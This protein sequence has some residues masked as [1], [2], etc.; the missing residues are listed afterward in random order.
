MMEQRK[1]A[2]LLMLGGFILLGIS[3]FVDFEG[4]KDK[5]IKNVQP[6]NELVIN[7]LS[8]I[9]MNM[10][11]LEIFLPMCIILLEGSISKIMSVAMAIYIA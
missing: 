10:G 4:A 3:R 7:N 9:V 11:F 5:F 1:S 6:H 8:L 2:L